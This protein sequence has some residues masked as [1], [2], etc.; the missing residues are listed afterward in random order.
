MNKSIKLYR[1]E[2]VILLYGLLA[3]YVNLSFEEMNRV[4]NYLINNPLEIDEYSD[5]L[6]DLANKDLITIKL[7]SY[8]YP[9]HRIRETYDKNGNTLTTDEPCKDILEFLASPEMRDRVVSENKLKIEV[10]VKQQAL[11]HRVLEQYLVSF[12]KGERS[13]GDVKDLWSYAKQK[14]YV[15]WFVDNKVSKSGRTLNINLL[16]TNKSVVSNTV[17]L[18]TLFALKYEG[19]INIE[20]IGILN[21][22]DFLSPLPIYVR[23]Q[24]IN[25]ISSYAKDIKSYEESFEDEWLEKRDEAQESLI[26][27]GSLMYRDNDIFSSSSRLLLEPKGIQILALLMENYQNTVSYNSIIDSCWEEE[28]DRGE[29]DNVNREDLLGSIYTSISNMRVILKNSKANVEIKT[30]Y[31]E[32]YVLLP[33][34]KKS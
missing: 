30:K 11:I 2:G 1:S 7:I 3:G 24:M 33:I 18:T 27:A 13:T 9:N 34:L 22:R 29:L 14:A 20:D 15:L 10:N 19:I 31:G 23:F 4:I 32:G 6:L 25:G 5:A 8:D 21:E 28:Q 17:L 16:E 26:E 12:I